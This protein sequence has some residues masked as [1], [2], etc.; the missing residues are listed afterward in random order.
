MNFV[1]KYSDKLKAKLITPEASQIDSY[2]KKYFTYSFDTNAARNEKQYEASITRW[3]HTIEKGLAYKNYRPGFGKDNISVLVKQLEEYSKAYDTSKFF[4]QTALSTLKEYVHKNKE[5]GYEDKA[6]EGR[7]TALP[8]SANNAGGIINFSVP[9]TKDLNYE[10]LVKSRHSVRHFSDK[11][12]DINL[13]KEAVALAQYAP[14][15]CNRQGWKC[16]IIQDK[17]KIVELLK[18]QNGNRGFGQE[19]DKLILVAGDLRAF[20]R[21]REVFQVFIDGGM[22]AMRVLDSLY[23]NGIAACP[24]SASLTWEQEKNARNIIGMDDAEVFILY[25]G[26]GN[27]PEGEC[28]TT[29]SERHEPYTELIC[30]TRSSRL[31]QK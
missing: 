7:I 30:C 21:S 25:I 16:Y 14:S 12:L 29:R 19:F 23:Y 22:Y 3:Y 20:N 17:K 13:V 18:N 2:K 4:Y 28:L 8:G 9:D 5:Y 15:A 1:K 31:S 24:L 11:P 10:D 6:L 26:I 27:Y